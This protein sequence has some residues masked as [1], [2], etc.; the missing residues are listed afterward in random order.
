[1]MDVIKNW[2]VRS[3]VMVAFAGAIF[4]T[5]FLGFFGLQRLSVVQG[6]AAEFRD[7]W[8]PGIEQ[9]GDLKFVSMRYRQ[10]QA[11]YIMLSGEDALAKEQ[12]NLD[13]I[14]AE[15]ET[16]LEKFAP[17]AEGENEKAML[18]DI[19]RTW[20]DYKT[21]QPKLAQLMHEQGLAAAEAYYTGEAK[22]LADVQRAALDASVVYHHDGAAK[23]AV[24]GKEA[25]ATAQLWL[26]IA[27][28]FSSG[29]A[30]AMGF[31][32]VRSVS[33][34]L[35]AMTNAMD[36]LARGNM[37]VPI[38]CAD[39]KDEVG[40]LAGS[41]SAF[42]SQ[43]AAAERSKAEQTE[44]IVA[45]IGTGLDYLA[46][47]DL[48]HRVTAE[49]SGAFAK[50][51]NDFNMAMDR[52]QDTM[53]NVLKSTGEIN[54]GAGEISGATDDLS[55][56]T[57][58]QAAGL[59]ET[60]A[61]LEEITNTVKKTAENA[62]QARTRVTSAKDAAEKG[63]DV[64][65]TA[66][67]AMDAISQSSKQITDIISVIDEIAFQTN[68]LAL[69]A[70]VEAARAGEAGKGFAVVAS[71]VRALAGRSSDAAKQ[72]KT[73]ISTSGEHVAAGVK[74]VGESGAA[75]SEIVNQVQQI[76]TLVTEMAHAAEQEATGIEEVNAAVGQ[77]DQM[78]Q[79]NAAMVEEST[80]AAKTLAGETQNLQALVR[81]FEVGQTAT[82]PAA[83]TSAKAQPAAARKPLPRTKVAVGGSSA[84]AQS[85]S[86]DEF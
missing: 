15:F 13:K 36:E 5:L 84:P 63:G 56:R 66:I 59:E 72:I 2:S 48:T 78:T 12:A 4:A 40:K 24:S 32:L 30:L 60:T 73:L 81:F 19:R 55:R 10:R 57:E 67:E 49:L 29:S 6:N 25:Y 69:N 22:K 51:K 82:E 50:L 14:Q 3:K 20:A 61:A 11:V 26:I 70:G 44:T 71:E 47:G 68:L 79:Q 34:P 62:R 80:A 27:M 38:P 86:W 43:L 33:T 85:E 54:S 39:Q 75:L 64:V 45:S 8:T 41:M 28:V 37:D 16:K 46:K 83:R 18:E 53:R 52:L 21:T 31:L 42:K 9:V 7:D 77:M 17:S 23:S 58:Q 76:N 35:W 65:A 1:M 74:F